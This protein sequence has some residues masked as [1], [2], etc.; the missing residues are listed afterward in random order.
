MRV[1]VDDARLD[2][3]WE[4]AGELGLPVIIHVADPVAFFEPLDK[5]NE[6]WEELRAH[7]DWHFPNPPFPPFLQI[8]GELA[9]LIARHPRTTFIGAHVG[10]YAENLDWVGAL[11]ERCPNFF[12]DISA[13][14]GE[15][16]RQPYSSRRFFL[17]SDRILFGADVPAGI[18]EYR[19]YYRFR[20]RTT[21]IS[22]TT[23]AKSGQAAGLSTGWP[24]R[25]EVLRRSISGMHPGCCGSSRILIAFWM[26]IYEG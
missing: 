25:T 6:R 4:T 8:M 21:S 11:L 19:I 26:P 13:R 14:L 24:C 1:A 10:C 23:P 9:N 2:P 16:G 5:H 12:V 3:I 18:E 15:L 22:T 7:P 17:N 20:K